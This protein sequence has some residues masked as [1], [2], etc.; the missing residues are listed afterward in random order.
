[1]A[2]RNQD[3]HREETKAVKK[4]L[5]EA[6]I[7]AKVT[8]GTGTA[9]AWLHINIGDP[10]MRN[11]F[12]PAPFEHLYTEEE[13]ALHRKVLKIVQEVT[14]RHGDYDGEIIVLAQ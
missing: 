5:A 9:W 7:K 10:K 2:W 14:G 4:A 13:L 11:G 12:K 3:N 1:M 6:G 8:H